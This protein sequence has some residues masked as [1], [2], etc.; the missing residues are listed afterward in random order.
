M[1]AAPA[2]S[3]NH[4]VMII[5]AGRAVTGPAKGLIQLVEGLRNTSIRW[6]LYCFSD[7]GRIPEELMRYAA[8][9]GIA[10]SYLNQKGK[11]YVSLFRQ[12][13]AEQRKHGFSVVQ[14]HGFKPSVIGFCLKMVCGIRWICFMHGVTSENLKVRLYHWLDGILQIWASKVVVVTSAQRAKILDGN[15]QRRVIVVHNAVNIDIPV[16]FS[17]VP[18]PVRSRLGLNQKNALITVVGRLSPEKGVDIFIEAFAELLRRVK[19]VDAVVVGDGQERTT[20]VQKADESG[21]RSHLHFIG[22]TE[23]PGDYM[24]DSDIIAIPSRSEGMPNVALEAMAL[25]KAVV[26]TAVGGTPEVLDDG[27]SGLLVPPAN[28]TA[29]CIAMELLVR[30]EQLRSRI[31]ARGYERAKQCFSVTA[32]VEKVIKIYDELQTLR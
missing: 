16:R 7:K 29:L 6:K 22:Y 12:A 15:N 25:Q 17:E 26:A 21:C 3:A 23:A 20:L 5:Y 31:A 4:S 13:M 18:I 2:Y 10:L 27:K 9:R 32:R 8:D 24:K 11:R 28:P 1:T 19:A 30:D 14:T